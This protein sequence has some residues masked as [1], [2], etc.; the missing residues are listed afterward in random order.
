MRI[1]SGQAQARIVKLIFAMTFS[2][3]RKPGTK[4]P[5][6]SCPCHI[7]RCAAYLAPD[8]V[9]TD[10]LRRLAQLQITEGCE[11]KVFFRRQATKT[12]FLDNKMQVPTSMRGWF[13]YWLPTEWASV[14]SYVAKKPVASASDLDA[15]EAETEDAAEAETEDAA[16]ADLRKMKLRPVALG[17]SRL[18]MPP[19][20]ATPRVPFE[21]E[22][23]GKRVPI[24]IHGAQYHLG[25]K[26]QALECDLIMHRGIANFYIDLAPAAG[27][28]QLGETK[29]NKGIAIR[30][31]KQIGLQGKELAANA[32]PTLPANFGREFTER[33]QAKLDALNKW[34]GEK[35]GPADYDIAKRCVL[36]QGGASEQEVFAAL[37]GRAHKKFNG[38]GL[39][40]EIHREVGRTAATRPIQTDMPQAVES[41]ED[42]VAWAHRREIETLR[43]A[44]K[45]ADKDPI[46][47]ELVDRADPKLLAEAERA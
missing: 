42:H 11:R 45:Y 10:A 20:R 26:V 47:R 32:K 18:Q 46:C 40:L 6:D 16:A 30:L 37:R 41:P 35:L 4:P 44:L 36:A 8:H 25:P 28:P 39:V 27:H 19:G 14:P 21:A 1:T 33:V 23:A 38:Y 13:V 31:E 12:D 7:D 22:V 17:G 2:A 43:D 3:P 24:P 15:A 29:A 34:F 5:K 9:P